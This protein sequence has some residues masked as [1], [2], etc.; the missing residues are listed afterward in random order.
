VLLLV[1]AANAAPVILHRLIGVTA[2]LDGGRTLAD[3]RPLFGPS[4]TRAGLVAGMLAPAL[5]SSVTGFGLLL[6]LIVGLL[7]MAGD[8]LASFIKRRMGLASEAQAIGLDQLPESLLPA[9]GASMLLP[10]GWA[11]ILAVGFGFMIL[12]M[13]LSP[14]LH[15]LG[16]RK[17]PY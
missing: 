16:L 4:K 10:L 14:L 1:F 12:E 15:R 3:G 17:H 9:I 5:I 7:A 8:L 13:L 6:G 11:D 2:A